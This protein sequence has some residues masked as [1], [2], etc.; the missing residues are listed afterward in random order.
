MSVQPRE[1]LQGLYVLTDEKLTPPEYLLQAVEQAITGGCRIIQYRDKT[2]SPEVRLEQARSL[3]ALCSKHQSLLI[4]NDD[5]GL[6]AAVEADGVHLGENDT[7]INIARSKLGKRLIGISCYNN[8][9]RAQQAER[10]GA[11]YIAFGSFF[12]SSIK[13]N[14]RTADI[15]I[16]IK[17]K[18]SIDIPIV[19]IGG[20]TLDNASL[21]ID[22]GA[23]MLAVITD[24]FAKK[25]ISRAANSYT[26]LFKN[27]KTH[28]K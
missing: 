13:P 17:A 10:D 9:Q 4:I 2:S 1:R 3:R 25:D 20:I 22:A 21:L 12:N 14:A 28:G 19:A 18:Q 23:D 24:V 26:H 7:D 8:L 5:I 6:A 15:D 27:T 11:D 16:L